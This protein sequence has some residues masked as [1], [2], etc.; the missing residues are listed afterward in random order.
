MFDVPVNMSP[1]GL[2]DVRDGGG[3]G[4][5]G[6]GSGRVEGVGRVRLKEFCWVEL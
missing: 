1:E 2:G 6:V 3:L 5:E 4:E